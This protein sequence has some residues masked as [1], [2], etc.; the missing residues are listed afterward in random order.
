MSD[1]E[2]VNLYSNA[3]FILFSFTEGPFDY[4]PVESMPCGMPVLTYNG[5]GTSET[6]INGVTGWLVNNDKELIDLAVNIWKNGHPS[7]MRTKCRERA[8]EFD[9]K[10][11]ADE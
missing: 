2:L 9:V 8:L 10:V 5:H 4:I 6:I 7:W 11:I 3:L 1:K